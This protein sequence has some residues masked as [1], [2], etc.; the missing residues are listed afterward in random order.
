MA[1]TNFTKVEDLLASSLSNMEVEQLGKLAD[2]AQRVERPEMRKLVEKATLAANKA[3]L[4]KKALL[5][6]IRKATKDF[7][8]PQFYEAIG[9]AEEELTGLLKDPKTL[10]PEQW[11]RLQQIRIKI[12]DFKKKEIELHSEKSSD[13]AIVENQR[14]KHINK[15]FNVK[16]EWLPLK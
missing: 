12:S 8:N 3:E 7:N 6:G 4:D 16:D 5:H 11:T 13:Q 14:H 1:K 10:K 2:I 15:R 9:M